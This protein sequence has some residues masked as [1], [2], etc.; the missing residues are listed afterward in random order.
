MRMTPRYFLAASGEWQGWPETREEA[1]EQD[2]LYYHKY[3]NDNP[4]PRPGHEKASVIFTKTG[5]HK[6]CSN[7][8]CYPAFE[9]A[10]YNGEPTDPTDAMNRGYDYFWRSTFGKYCGHNG[11][12]TIDDRCWFCE[13]EIL[14]NKEERR[15]TPRQQA[16]K[17][18]E[19]WYMPGEDDPCE[20]GHIAL[21]RVANGQC[22]ECT[23]QSTTPREVVIQ[24]HYPDMVI[25]AEAARSLGFKV[26]RT[27]L[28]CRKGHTA[29]RYLSNGACI[30][31][32]GR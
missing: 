6:C 15:N 29:W 26:Y 19:P 32:L 4:C 31:C 8:D 14:K 10:Q 24:D 13:Q 1:I 30:K 2:T 25:D 21:R 5:I 7:R 20:A 22:S 9:E 12:R 18:G 3:P 28:P 27:G 17:A 23:K 16:I 11:K